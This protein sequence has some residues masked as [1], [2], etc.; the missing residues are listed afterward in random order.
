MYLISQ[1]EIE[2]FLE[3]ALMHTLQTDKM[4]WPLKQALVP[5]TRPELLSI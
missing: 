4:Q 1:F 2:D 5:M 3:V